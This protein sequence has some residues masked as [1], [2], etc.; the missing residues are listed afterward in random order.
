MPTRHQR[1]RKEAFPVA[2]AAKYTGGMS[3]S[4]TAQPSSNGHSCTTAAAIHQPIKDRWGRHGLVTGDFDG[5]CW[6]FEIRT[7][8]GHRV[9][10]LVLE[11]DDRGG[12]I[13][14]LSI[15]DEA[16]RWLPHWLHRLIAQLHLPWPHAGHRDSGLGSLLVIYALKV[17]CDLHLQAVIVPGPI[18]A[19]ARGLFRNLGFVLHDEATGPAA[20]Y[21]IS[22]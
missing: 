21:R 8:R 14:E 16:T 11:I 13:V 18:P 17:A 19:P 15:V 6:R 5:R 10:Q 7:P 12:R 22:D 1:E 20:T 2:A 9:G 3:P 4:P